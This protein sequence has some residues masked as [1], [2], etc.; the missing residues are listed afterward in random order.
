MTVAIRL[1]DILLGSYL[2]CLIALCFV[3]YLISAFYKKKFQK[4]VLQIGF[5]A[6]AVLFG[7]YLVTLPLSGSGSAVVEGLQ[8]GLVTSGSIAVGYNALRL[9]FIMRRPG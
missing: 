9:Y 1:P 2:L 6:G 7:L 4:P 3:A 8:A 5:V